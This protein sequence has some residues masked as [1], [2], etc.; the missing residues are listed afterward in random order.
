M[1]FIDDI[2][3][4]IAA[5]PAER[6][7]MLF[8]ATL[9]GEIGRM[10]ARITHDPQT[11]RI[12]RLTDKHEN[13]EQKVHFVDDLAHK[14]SPA[15][16]PAARCLA[17]SGRD[18]HAT[19]RDADTIADQLTGAS[20]AAAPLHGD[21][22]QG[23]RNRTALTAMRRC[24]CRILV[25]TDVAAR[26]IDVPAS[27]TSS[28]TTCRSS[29]KTILH[30][31]HRPLPYRQQWRRRVAGEP[32][33]R[34][35]READRGALPKTDS[36]R[37]RSRP[38]TQSAPGAAAQTGWLETG[39]GPEAGTTRTV[40]I[41]ATAM[42]TSATANPAAPRH[43]GMPPV[44]SAAKAIAATAPTVSTSAPTTSA[45]AERAP[46]HAP[47]SVRTI[48]AT[49][50]TTNRVANIAATVPT[51]TVARVPPPRRADGFRQ[52]RVFRRCAAPDLDRSLIRVASLPDKM[53]AGDPAVWVFSPRRAGEDSGQ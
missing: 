25:A 51:A 27:P 34:H 8:S 36:G 41:T 52:R 21:M 17:G 38:R 40:A 16:P 39:A 24:Q 53:T 11:I 37:C 23:A 33:R 42:A 46:H 45:T 50:P 43:E 6:Q 44:V 31:P 47:M 30:Q 3:T 14:E 13:I 15:R 9:D 26:G 12:C 19:K 35:P 29:R 7:T 18:L 32:R 10:A 20:F 22:H 48:S 4:I 49:V 1:G 2:E 28:T 5:T